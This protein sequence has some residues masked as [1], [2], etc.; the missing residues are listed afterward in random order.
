MLKNNPSLHGICGYT[1][2]APSFSADYDNMGVFMEFIRAE[3]PIITAWINANTYYSTSNW[4]C[5]YKMDYEYE[6]ILYEGSSNIGG[7]SKT[8]VLKRRG[9]EDVYF[10]Y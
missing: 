1:G 4:A 10:Y 3:S 9:K 5:L 7:D 2:S 6:S 8:I